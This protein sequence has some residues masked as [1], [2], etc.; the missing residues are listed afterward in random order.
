MTITYLPF[1]GAN[2]SRRVG[3][4]AWLDRAFSGVTLAVR[5]MISDRSQP[6]WHT[7]NDH[8][9]RDI[10]RSGIEAKIIRDQQLTISTFGL[11]PQPFLHSLPLGEDRSESGGLSHRA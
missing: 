2:A 8:L 7:L 5:T 9:L 11:G 3:K 4:R 6:D 1:S 10:G